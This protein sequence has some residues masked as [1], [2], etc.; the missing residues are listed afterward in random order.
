[1]KATFRYGLLMAGLAT[2]ATGCHISQNS[3]AEKLAAHRPLYSPHTNVL[4]PAQMLMHPGPGVDGPGPGV[5]MSRPGGGGG[6]GVIAAG[7]YSDAANGGGGGGQSISSQ[8]GFVGMDG[9]KVF[10]DVTA[11]GAFDSEPLIFPGRY[12]FAQGAIYRLKLTDIPGNAGVELYP[13]LE[14]AP[15]TPRT[16][17]FLAHNYIPFQITNE[18]FAQV[19]SGN[20]VTKVIYLPDAEHQELALAGVETLVSTRLDPGVDPIVEA[21]RKGSI[22]AIIR[23]GNKDLQ[24]PGGNGGGM[25]VPVGYAA[26]GGYGS[27]PDGSCGPNGSGNGGLAAFMAGV[28]MPSYGMP[29]TGTPIGLPGPPHLPLGVPAGLQQHVIKNH[30]HMHIPGPTE[31]MR[32]DVKQKPGLSYPKPVDHV[33]IVETSKV[34]H[35]P[36][37]QP[38]ADRT[39]ILP[40]EMPARRVHQGL[41][42]GAT[43]PCDD[44]NC[45]PGAVSTDAYDSP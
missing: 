23:L 41:H 4:P 34:P 7:C 35:V 45:E 14:V 29:I 43:V 26:G 31:R 18:D 8:V 37:I 30:T 1:M 2:M 42:H 32:I 39:H 3:P 36:F 9:M 44:G 12:N 22:L 24:A 11:P 6:G 19:L 25:V 21:D 17:A 16:E 40:G 38:L 5:L 15:T 10:W 28:N 33:R 13:T 27:G 20:F